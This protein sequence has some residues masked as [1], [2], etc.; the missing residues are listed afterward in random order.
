MHYKP[1]DHDENNRL[2]RLGL[3]GVEARGEVSNMRGKGSQTL[4]AMLDRYRLIGGHEQGNHDPETLERHLQQIDKEKR[5][6]GNNVPAQ[7]KYEFSP[8]EER[9]AVNLRT[10]AQNGD[11]RGVD[12]VLGTSTH[13]DNFALIN[14]ADENGWQAIHE[15]A[16]SGSL[17]VMI[18]LRQVRSN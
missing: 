3:A 11:L 10:A 4:P 1:V 12:H 18:P 9:S 17:E 16:R 8:E 15:A 6:S 7:R 14:A 13:G 5:L 2:D